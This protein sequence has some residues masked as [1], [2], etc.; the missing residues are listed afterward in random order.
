MYQQKSLMT[1]NTERLFIEQLSEADASFIFEL[2]NTE[3][4]IKYIGNRNINSPADAVTY[5]QKINENPDITYWSVKLRAPKAAIGLITLI[6]RDY[7]D[8]NDIGF[9]FLPAFS[10]K[11]YAYEATKAVLLN[12]AKNNII[13]NILAITLPGNKSSVKLIEKL[14]LK[15]EKI[16][17]QNNEKLHLYG[18][19][20]IWK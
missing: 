15:F 17:E 7:L 14:G 10:K 13:E 5:I 11:G 9:A 1:I 6:K 18:A 12:L 3:D 19:S 4:W 8:F 16:I 20:G 2:L